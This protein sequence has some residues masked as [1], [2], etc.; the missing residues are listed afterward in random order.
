MISDSDVERWGDYSS[1]QRDYT[2]P[3]MVWTASSYANSAKRNATWLTQL[4]RP[5][6]NVSTKNP[7]TNQVEV[8]AYPN[9]TFNDLELT[10]DIYNTDHLL[11][12]IV[13]T[14][15]RLVKLIHN[16][17][18]KRQGKLHFS[19]STAPL[20]TGIYFLQIVADGETIGNKKIVVQ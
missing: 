14:N 10:F 5:S 15:G 4:A 17:K 3:G 9:P 16:D 2:N 8:L 18:P 7:T 1:N 12:Q 13:D 11:I 6:M 19:M 20:Q